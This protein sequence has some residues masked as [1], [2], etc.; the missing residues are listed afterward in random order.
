MSSC[1]WLS[2][3]S[4]RVS[5]SIHIR[6]GGETMSLI[7]P[8]VTFTAL[9]RS[10]NTCGT[11]RWRGIRG[12][13]LSFDNQPQNNDNLSAERQLFSPRFG[14]SVISEPVLAQCS[15]PFLNIQ[16]NKQMCRQ[17]FSLSLSLVRINTLIKQFVSLRGEKKNHFV[18]SVTVK[19]N[20][21]F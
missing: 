7:T 20:I 9:P 6:P 1:I 13:R 14:P 2:I 10:H 12:P 5:N 17:S 16:K 3:Q 11:R 8:C 19:I 21:Y 15:Q 18:S 4:G